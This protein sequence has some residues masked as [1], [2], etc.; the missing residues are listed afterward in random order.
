MLRRRRR[1]FRDRR[2]QGRETQDAGQRRAQLVAH[3]GQEDGLGFRGGLQAGLELAS[4]RDVAED[5]DHLHG[6]AVDVADD[7]GGA[8]QPDDRSV[9]GHDRIVARLGAPGVGGVEQ[10][11]QRVRGVPAVLARQEFGQVTAGD[12]FGRVAELTARGRGVSDHAVAVDAQKDVV[13]IVRQQTVSRLTR[14]QL[15]QG[16]ALFRDVLYDAQQ[17]ARAALGVRIRLGA[18][19]DPPLRPIAGALQA[20]R[21]VEADPRPPRAGD[22]FLDQSLVVGM[23]ERQRVFKAW[24]RGRSRQA[25]NIEDAIGPVADARIPVETPVAQAGRL[26]G[27][28][29]GARLLGDPGVGLPPDAQLMAE[30]YCAFDSARQGA[31]L[32]AGGVVHRRA[33]A[34]VG[35]AERAER[36]PLGRAEKG[37]GVV[38]HMGGAHDIGIGGEA[39]IAQR[40]ADLEDARAFQGGVVAERSLTRDG[41]FVEADVAAEPLPVAVQ[42]AHHAHGGAE[43]LRRQA[44]ERV[45]RLRRPRIGG[46]QGGRR[47]G[48]H[49]ATREHGVLP[50]HGSILRGTSLRRPCAGA[51]ARGRSP[52]LYRSNTRLP[53]AAGYACSPETTPGLSDPRAALGERS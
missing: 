25:V 44:R 14:A 16:A 35:D 50:N 27:D 47:R 1:E 22:H 45:E 13:A 34:G 5:A 29:Q 31:Q 24:R 49:V 11:E 40:V 48:Q 46:G 8:F 10:V 51:A 30:L 52:R 21:G 4:R 20:Q 3:I 12:V 36:L 17:R 6:L 43:D 42:E 39:R 23:I 26:F 38:T 7:G 18:R 19:A 41:G 15:R 2:Q 28:F 33:R 53:Q 9:R 32:R 37:A